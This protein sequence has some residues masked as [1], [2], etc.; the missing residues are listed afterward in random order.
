MPV[1]GGSGAAR[2]MLP[3]RLGPSC[4]MLRRGDGPA[5]FSV[6]IDTIW[7]GSILSG[8]VRLPRHTLERDRPL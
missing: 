2:G 8:A 1:I 3:F 4:R 7:L 6:S 5:V